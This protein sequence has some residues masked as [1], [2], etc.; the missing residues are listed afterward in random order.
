MVKLYN[1][2]WQEKERKKL[3]NRKKLHAKKI[4]WWAK[5]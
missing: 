5:F 4:A 2:T 1:A 3:K